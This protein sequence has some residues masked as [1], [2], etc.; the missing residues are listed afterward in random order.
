MLL[1]L[2]YMLIC[3][4]VNPKNNKHLVLSSVISEKR[5]IIYCEDGLQ[6]EEHVFSSCL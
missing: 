2:F 5:G 4:V 1:L 3:S 6:K